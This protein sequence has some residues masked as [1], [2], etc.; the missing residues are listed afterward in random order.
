MNTVLS[1]LS[2]VAQIATAAVIAGALL[3]GVAGLAP[4]HATQPAGHHAAGTTVAATA[5]K[6][7]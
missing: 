7:Q 5:V 4:A 2:K 6:A 3:I 1:M